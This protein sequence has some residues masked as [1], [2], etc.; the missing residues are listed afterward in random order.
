MSS[1]EVLSDCN[2]FTASPGAHGTIVATRDVN[3][4]QFYGFIE[5]PGIQINQAPTLVQLRKR[6]A[7]TT[8]GKFVALGDQDINVGGYVSVTPTMGVYGPGQYDD[9]SVTPINGSYILSLT[10]SYISTQ[11]Q[12]FVEDDNNVLLFATSFIPSFTTPCTLSTSKTID[13]P[14][15]RDIRVRIVCTGNGVLLLTKSYF[16]LST[17]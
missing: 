5:G 16:T 9:M 10:V 14:A 6:S 13:L 12:V 7:L 8:L 17:A 3:N 2:Y 11:I 15:N 4:F 1:N